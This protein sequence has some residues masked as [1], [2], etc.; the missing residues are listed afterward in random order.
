DVVLVNLGVWEEGLL[1]PPGNPRGLRRGADLAEPGVTLVNRE[2]GAGS[3]VLLEE[4]LEA[5]GVSPADVE[6]FDRLA[7]SH[8]EVA[9]AVAA[10]RAD[11]GVSS[12][13]VAAAYGLDFVPLREARYDLA[14]F[15][16]YLEDEPVR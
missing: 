3:R 15:R 14:L 10:G 9:E 11:A 7:Y 8:T 2:E 13:S 4:A 5:D 12:A 6:G 1:V 16:E